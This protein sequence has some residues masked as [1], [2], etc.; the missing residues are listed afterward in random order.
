MKNLDF[1]LL[2]DL[3]DVVSLDLL[4][5][6]TSLAQF[7]EFLTLSVLLD[8][9]SPELQF[10]VELLLRVSLLVALLVTLVVRLVMMRLMRHCELIC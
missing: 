9:A 2:G 7:G 10:G 5:D 4:V 3:L 8:Q 6:L 1:S